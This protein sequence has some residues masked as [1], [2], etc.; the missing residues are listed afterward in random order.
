MFTDYLTQRSHDVDYRT[1]QTLAGNLC[2]VFWRGVEDLNPHQR[3]H[4]LTE[5]IYQ[6][7]RQRVE[8]RLD[9]GKRLSSGAVLAT[10]RAF[11]LDIQG[12]ATEDPATWAR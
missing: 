2:Q 4:A 7:W 3:D 1:L 10:V 12:W 8:Q 5:E 11:Y 9:G 6:Q